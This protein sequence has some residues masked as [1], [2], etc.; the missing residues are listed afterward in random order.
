MPFEYGGVAI[1]ALHPDQAKNGLA[2]ASCVAP[3]LSLWNQTSSFD[4]RRT[5]ALALVATR[6]AAKDPGDGFVAIF[7]GTLRD[8][9][10]VHIIAKGNPLQHFTNGV[11]MSEVRDES[12]EK[13]SMNGLLGVQ[14]HTVPPMKIEFR[15]IRINR[16]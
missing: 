3:K 15:I 10:Q 16:L 9:S 1:P 4:R 8:W 7:D 5:G 12:P 2:L 14:A 13:R 6:L 11:L